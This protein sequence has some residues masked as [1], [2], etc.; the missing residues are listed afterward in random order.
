MSTFPLRNQDNGIIQFSEMTFSLLFLDLKT[1]QTPWFSPCCLFFPAGK[2]SPQS[3]RFLCFVYI[4]VSSLRMAAESIF[5]LT[6]NQDWH[7][8]IVPPP[9]SYPSTIFYNVP[10]SVLSAASSILPISLEEPDQLLSIRAVF[11][12]Q[13]QDLFPLHLRSTEVLFLDTE[14]NDVDPLLCQ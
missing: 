8:P 5:L 10:F 11:L 13:Q 2:G 4:F 1:H 3:L 14:T 9:C 7:P 6:V 12:D